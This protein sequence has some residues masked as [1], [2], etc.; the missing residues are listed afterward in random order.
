MKLHSLIRGGVVA[1]GPDATIADAAVLMR[2]EDIGSL[3]VN[4][5]TG[6]LVGII[7]ERDLVRCVAEMADPAV[8]RVARFMTGDPLV[9]GPDDGVEEVAA[10]MLTMGLRHLPVV[11]DGRVL[12]MVS[13]RD[14]LEASALPAT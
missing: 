14:L 6:S 1:V 3:I 4:D 11:E 12:G 10:R 13:I 9:A 8:V 5:G 7:T 2:R